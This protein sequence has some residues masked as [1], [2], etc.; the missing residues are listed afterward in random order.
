VCTRRGDGE[1]CASGTVYYTRAFA[2]TTVRGGGGG[3]GGGWLV[4]GGSTAAKENQYRPYI[5]AVA[6][7]ASTRRRSRGLPPPSLRVFANVYT[8]LCRAYVQRRA[9]WERTRF[10]VSFLFAA[11]ETA[12]GGTRTVSDLT[13]AVRRNTAFP[14]TNSH[15]QTNDPVVVRTR[16]GSVTHLPRVYSFRTTRGTAANAKDHPENNRRS[17]PEKRC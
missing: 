11:H 7:T 4:G 5:P 1:G 3:G 14:S 13:S 15:A 8:N 16:R 6:A 12:L 9:A 10:D 2:G 17:D